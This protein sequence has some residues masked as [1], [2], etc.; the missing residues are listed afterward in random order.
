MHELLVPAALQDFPPGL[1]VTVYLLI[2]LPPVSVGA[3]QETSDTASAFEVAATSVGAP[4]S[5]RGVTAA[6]DSEG[7]PPPRTL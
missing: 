4:G 7:A 6:D 1:A 3:V 5:P 2:A